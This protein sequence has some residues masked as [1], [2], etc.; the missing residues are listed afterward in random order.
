MDR[1]RFGKKNDNYIDHFNEIFNSRIKLRKE[2]IYSLI[3]QK[4][5]NDYNANKIK[6]SKY[7]YDV[8]KITL[9]AKTQQIFNSEIYDEKT[10]INDSINIF[11]SNNLKEIKGY[12]L[13]LEILLDKY[14]NKN[15]Y[16]IDENL[17]LL[18]SLFNLINNNVNDEEIIYNILYVLA[19]YTSI[20]ENN[21]LLCVLCSEKFF[22][23]WELLF[24]IKNNDIIWEIINLI[25]NIT[26]NN[27]IGVS[28]FLKNSSFLN[29]LHTVFN[30]FNN[31]DEEKLKD[32]DLD[33]ISFLL[34][35]ISNILIVCL[36]NSNI[37]SKFDII[38][39]LME[40][41]ILFTQYNNFE[42]YFKSIK[43]I[44]YAV[45]KNNELIKVLNS[46]NFI[47]ELL[48]KKKY[49]INI[50]L[51]YSLNIIFDNYL[52]YDDDINNFLLLDILKFNFDYLKLT[53]LSTHRQK[54]FILLSN[55]IESNDNIY[56][57]FFS[58]DNIL[59]LILNYFHNS[60]NSLEIKEVG[61]FF[62]I[63]IPMLEVNEIFELEKKKLFEFTV[64]HLKNNNE[65]KDLIYILLEILNCFFDFG[66]DLLSYLGGVN[67]FI[68]KF[69]ELGGNEILD[70]LL[71]LQDEKINDKINYIKELF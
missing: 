49:F 71:I 1:R 13:L 7:L 15:K 26:K 68:K 56:K 35:L 64:D 11:K 67:I 47:K 10:I 39:K 16:I 23:I 22:K 21:C 20:C 36:N 46:N 63:L 55:I 29:Y 60:S 33:L 30:N 51:R 4:R 57:E 66:E 28:F 41:I 65:N 31:K 19:N 53:N 25:N 8:I 24:D 54:I 45:D 27:Y 12:L 37:N 6:K 59:E 18:F 40:I 43:I 42:I 14:K 17:D 38:V 70:N 5:L 34:N 52:S 61:Y 9:T 58:D 2:K 48:E 3:I 62:S 69:E 44:S 32:D 50:D